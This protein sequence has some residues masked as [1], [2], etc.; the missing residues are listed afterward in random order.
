M[1]IK[2]I[3]IVLALSLALSGAEAKVFVPK[4]KNCNTQLT[5]LPAYSQRQGS[6]VR[7]YQSADGA[8]Q[9]YF[10]VS[11]NTLYG[12]PDWVAWRLTSSH[13]SG[14]ASRKAV[15]FEPDPTIKGCPTKRSY[16]GVGS[17]NPKHSR[18]HFCPAADNKWSADAMHDCFYM[19]NIAPQQQQMNTGAWG[20]LED[21]CRRWARKYGEVFIA[22]GPVITKGMARLPFNR[23]ISNP[24]WFYKVVMRR[25]GNS[26]KAIGWIFDATGKCAAMS[27]DEVE[28]L[29]GL[30]FFHN[31]PDNIEEKVEATF[32]LGD[33][34]QAS[35]VK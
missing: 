23:K 6:Q 29:C 17:M 15:D 24:E 30:D 19:T 14:T 5:E 25:D 12:I 26:Y 33:W 21:L 11:F 9:P 16:N 13:T 7:Y 8:A 27:V 1:E 32:S 10:V 20:T 34:P 22:A 35:K 2:K 18:G 28:E 3:S 4:G 31:L